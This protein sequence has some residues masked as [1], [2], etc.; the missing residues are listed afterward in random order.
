M[1]HLDI[2]QRCHLSP[3]WSIYRFQ[4]YTIPRIACKSSFPGLISPPISHL[5]TQ[6][7]LRWSRLLLLLRCL[8]VTQLPSSLLQGPRQLKPTQGTK[9]FIRNQPEN[10]EGQPSPA[11]FSQILFGP[12]CCSVLLE[13]TALLAT[14]RQEM[15]KFESPKAP[16]TYI[17]NL[18]QTGSSPT[19]SIGSGCKPTYDIL[20][21]GFHIGSRSS[22]SNWAAS[23]AS[24]A[25]PAS[26]GS[27]HHDWGQENLASSPMM[28]DNM[29][30]NNGDSWG[31]HYIY[32]AL[33]CPYHYYII[34]HSDIM[35]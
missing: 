4:R 17:D 24:S 14:K 22:S 31:Y 12:C 25:S 20:W 35:I 28:V 34:I 23:R 32:M 1:I 30:Y 11:F 13:C 8:Q 29:G 26:L 6:P 19:Y 3:V 18:C 15:M 10:P 9:Y 7:R 33:I 5:S 16:N 27:S 2:L 21:R